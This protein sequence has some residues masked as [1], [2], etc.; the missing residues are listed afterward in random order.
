MCVLTAKSGESCSVQGHTVTTISPTQEQEDPSPNQCET[1][2]IPCSDRGIFLFPQ[3]MKKKCPALSSCIQKQLMAVR[4]KGL[5]KDSSTGIP[6]EGS[7][8][9]IPS[10]HSQPAPVPGE[11]EAAPVCLKSKFLL[12]LLRQKDQ[13]PPVPSASL[14]QGCDQPNSSLLWAQILRTFKGENKRKFFPALQSSLP[15]YWLHKWVLSHLSLHSFSSPVH[16]SFL[17]PLHIK[18]VTTNSPILPHLIPKIK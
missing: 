14:S 11:A 16:L 5:C 1:P 12:Q 18:Q 17:C 8:S 3:R 7:N 15:M 10:Q 9:Q 13:H 6:A 2:R 4:P